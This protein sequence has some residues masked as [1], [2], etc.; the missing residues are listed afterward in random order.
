MHAFT[1]ARQLEGTDIVASAVHPGVVVTVFLQNNGLMYKIAAPVRKLFNRSSPVDGAEPAVYLASA[2]E[3]ATITGEYY[4]PPHKREAPLAR[5][6]Q[7]QERL[8]KIS[9]E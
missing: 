6:V 3:A 2:P 9:M 1:L 4:E 5:D 8:W 7:A